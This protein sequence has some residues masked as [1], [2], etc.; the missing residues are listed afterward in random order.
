LGAAPGV[1]LA[2]AESLKERFPA[3]KIAG[4]YSP[5]FKQL[6]A[7][8]HA[9]MVAR[10]HAAKPDILL[11]AFG[12]P[13]GECWIYDNLQELNVPLSIQL[14][15]SFDFLAGTAQRAP[16]IWQRFACEWLYR[17]LSDPM[18]LIPRY[19]SNAWFL[20]RKLLS[21]KL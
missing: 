2:A 18:R 1:A 11:V 9:D 21:F 7:A 16:K 4:T 12:Q 14:G 6:N 3:L 10:I 5:P 13:K 15:A 20:A 8:E 19:A 17:A